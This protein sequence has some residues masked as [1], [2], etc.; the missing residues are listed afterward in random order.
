M[1]NRRRGR[2]PCLWVR[3]HVWAIAI[4]TLVLFYGVFMVQTTMWV[5][6]FRAIAEEKL[7]E[8]AIND[9]RTQLLNSAQMIVDEDTTYDINALDR[10]ATEI[11]APLGD[12]KVFRSRLNHSLKGLLMENPVENGSS[13]AKRSA[14]EDSMEKNKSKLISFSR[15]NLKRMDT[16]AVTT[17]SPKT[18]NNTTYHLYTDAK[19]LP[20]ADEKRM[21]LN[22]QVPDARR[23]F[24]NTIVNQTLPFIPLLKS[25]HFDM[26]RLVSTRINQLTF[27]ERHDKV[28]GYNATLAYLAS[29][30]K[31]VNSS[32]EVFLFFTCSNRNGSIND[33]NPNCRIAR[34]KVYAIFAKS[35]STNRLVTIYAGPYC[36]WNHTNAFMEDKD[37]RLKALPTILRWDGGT[38]GALRSTWGVLVDTSIL[39]DPIVRYLFRTLNAQDSIFR[40]SE[41]ATKEIVTLEG[42]ASFRAFTKGYVMKATMYPLYIMMI[43]GRLPHNNRLWCPWCRQ[44][45]L[46]VE[47]AFYAFAPPHAKLV[48]VETFDRQSEWHDPENPFKVDPQLAMKG[49][50]WFYRIYPSQKGQLLTF[51]RVKKKFY[52]HEDLQELFQDSTFVVK[53][54]N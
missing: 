25:R 4:T 30:T 54:K 53:T 2:N 31:P 46:P 40:K 37:L 19:K 47:Y 12:K 23:S 7:I 50:P 16:T 14:L 43:S 39:F 6:S 1:Q 45:E 26:S 17:L 42:Y 20:M 44:A 11:E 24:A 21:Q 49:V 18:I 48:L 28:I 38:P 35:P 15:L 22:T 36:D 10:I 27:E 29:Y 3:R 9:E 8:E 34:E 51:E 32:I 33:W 52:V 13:T 41:V 5:R